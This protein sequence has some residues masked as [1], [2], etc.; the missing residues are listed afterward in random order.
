MRLKTTYTGLLLILI[1]RLENRSFYSMIE[2]LSCDEFLFVI[3][4]G[5]KSNIKIK[6]DNSKLY[7]LFSFLGKRGPKKRK[8]RV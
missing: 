7:R 5:D 6:L 3:I 4:F 8:D 2:L 1:L